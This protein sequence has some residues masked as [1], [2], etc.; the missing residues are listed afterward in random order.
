ML[1]VSP[2]DA[3]DVSKVV[4]F[5][6]KHGLSPSV[7]AGGYGIAGWAVA[8][9]IVIDM[10]RIRELDIEAPVDAGDGKY[11]WTRLKDMPAPGSKGKGRVQPP[12]L[13]VKPEVVAVTEAGRPVGQRSVSTKRRREDSPPTEHP[14]VTQGYARPGD[15][16]HLRNY[17]AASQAVAEFLRGPPLPVEEG[18]EVPRQ[19]PTNRRR[20]HSPTLGNNDVPHL[21]LPPATTRQLSGDSETSSGGAS[22][23]GLGERTLSGGTAASTPRDG[24]PK[25]GEEAQPTSAPSIPQPV[26]S[27]AGAD[28]FGYMSLPSTTT[29]SMSSSVLMSHRSFTRAPTGAVSSSSASMA[30]NI[31]NTG[32][33]MSLSNI[34]S[35]PPSMSGPFSMPPFGMPGLGGLASIS[36]PARP[37]HTH[38][39]LTVG[40]GTRQKEIDMF[41]AENPLEGISRITGEK[42]NGL[43]PY[44]VPR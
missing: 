30:R 3:E 21:D 34:P 37:V 4:K 5:C 44:H 42:E 15:D 6:V 14:A 18:G 17:D 25:E 29:P 32:M 43:V 39:Y 35:M 12:P 36:A 22:S 10:S 16:G 38:A 20:L 2:V 31:F 24:T 19:P 40:A 9:D 23:L 7:I 33:P 11:Q 13:P 1:V 41:T 27:D 8:G 28:P 26:S